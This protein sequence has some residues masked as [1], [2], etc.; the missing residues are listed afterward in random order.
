MPGAAQLATAWSST[1]NGPSQ[2]RSAPN[3]RF[4]NILPLSLA[5]SMWDLGHFEA[6]QGAEEP[7]FWFSGRGRTSPQ[8]MYPLYCNGVVVALCASLQA[9]AY[10]SVGCITPTNKRLQKVHH[11]SAGECR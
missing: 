7:I 8:Q 11:R 4:Q 5:Y 10:F 1:E 3:R 9:P 6:A 2:N